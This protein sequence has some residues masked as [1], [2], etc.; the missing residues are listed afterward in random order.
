M[1]GLRDRFPIPV[2]RMIFL[3]TARSIVGVVL[4]RLPS[5][6]CQRSVKIGILVCQ[7]YRG[8]AGRVE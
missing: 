8:G 6:N 7:R 1:T 3:W 4:L 5:H 2:S